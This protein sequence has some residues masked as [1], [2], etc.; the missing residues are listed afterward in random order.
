MKDQLAQFY[1]DFGLE[2]DITDITI[3]NIPFGSDDDEPIISLAD[4]KGLDLIIIH[5]ENENLTPLEA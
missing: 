1:M 5:D 4:I 3:G 2:G